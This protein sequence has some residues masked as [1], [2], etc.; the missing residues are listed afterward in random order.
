MT[1]KKEN[2][3]I[4]LA[5]NIIIPVFILNKGQSFFSFF[6]SLHILILALAF[7]IGYG[8]FDWLRNK[9]KNIISL[10]GVLNVLSTGGLALFKVK[11]IWFAVKEALFPLLIGLFVLFSA[12]TKKSFFEYLCSSAPLFN[13]TRIKECSSDKS[14]KKLFRKSTLW[15]S[16]SFF[17]SAGLNF[18]LALFIFT[19]S[20]KTLVEQEKEMLLN[21]QI[22][23]MTWL[24]FVVIG[25][26]MT[27]F[28][29]FIL[30]SFMKNLKQ[31]TGLSL[32]EIMPGAKPQ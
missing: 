29:G 2:L 31:I 15:F 24:G 3:F 30:W 16:L 7:P 11:G 5:C 25:L 17:L 12:Y 22:A 4:N 23:D 6:N 18:A 28:A 20:A 8:A 26:P 13:W 27:V 10:F 19:D 14:L 32:E 9:R 1:Q 21:Q